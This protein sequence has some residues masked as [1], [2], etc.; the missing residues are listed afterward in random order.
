[1]KRLL[2]LVLMLAL[3]IPAQAFVLAD[4]AAEA[5][6]EITYFREQL[7]TTAMPYYNDTLWLQALE[8]RMNVKLTITG[9]ASGDDYTTAV[10]IL[11]ASGNYP[12]LLYND[13]NNYNGGVRA[14]IEDGVVVPISE[15][16]EYKALMPTWF[17]IL[18]NDAEFYRAVT[19]D[20]G[21]S[22]VFCAL[23]DDIRR[24]A[25]WGYAIRKDWLDRLG[26]EVPTT[27]DELYEVLVAFKEQDANGNGDSTDEIPLVSCN[28]W[29]TSHPLMDTLANAFSLKV[30][31]MY[32]DPQTDKVTY[33][34]EYNDGKNFIE[35]VET[36]SKWYAEGLIDPEFVSQDSASNSA[37]ITSDKAGMFFC[38][39]DNVINYKTS[40]K[41]TLSDGGYADPELV[42]IYGLTPII[43]VDGKPYYNDNA[44]VRYAHTNEGNCVTTAAVDNGTIDKLLELLDFMYTEEGSE[45][46]NWGVDGVSYT[47]DADGKHVW[48]E[49]VTNDPEYSFSDAVFKYALPT[50]GRW[51]KWMS[52]EAWS[53]MNLADSDAKRL[54]EN[55]TLA[56]T[57]LLLPNMLLTAE[58]SETYTQIMT[59]VNTAVSEVFLSVITGTKTIDDAYAL[60]DQVKGMGVENAIACYQS[61]YDRYLSK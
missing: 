49:L 17:S 44:M 26:L 16:E 52:Y 24:S 5:P 56:D 34:T 50:W 59:D 6:V 7:N 30:N 23:E 38:F 40:L 61:A 28:M 45:L 13:W 1:M 43:G 55:Y 8:E 9:P 20:D 10:N 53:A 51:P 21:T 48:T 33:W 42:E 35:Y 19:L 18:D 37:K 15:V 54:H 14:A 32:K 57:G 29:G 22:A 39:P 31:E 60:V 25:Y 47:I 58:E 27:V 41:T 3:L 2:V 46:Q 36:M 11:L 12:D 4:E